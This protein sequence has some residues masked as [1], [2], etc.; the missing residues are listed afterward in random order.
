MTT[1]GEWAGTAAEA[2]GS[3]SSLHSYAM[4]CGV[5]RR[6]SRC[7]APDSSARARLAC[8]FDSKQTCSDAREVLP[9]SPATYLV[10]AVSARLVVSSRGACGCSRDGRM[11]RFWYRVLRDTQRLV[12]VASMPPA[13]GLP[14]ATLPCFGALAPAR[15]VAR[16]PNPVHRFGS[17]AFLHGRAELQQT[18][19][20]VSAQLL[21]RNADG[22]ERSLLPDDRIAWQESLP[23]L[24]DEAT[25]ADA[26][27]DGVPVDV[28]VVSTVAEAEAAVQVLL[29][30]AGTK[31][32]P[33]YHAIDTEAC[34]RERSGCLR[35]R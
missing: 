4:S 29:A 28:S 17:V 26:P 33:V 11:R 31:G 21:W 20:R 27:S 1:S 25:H 14:A 18:Q 32:K 22:T 5:R 15:N 23:A 9:L 34:L 8:S 16:Q 6:F 24:S 30:T 12:H 2:T 19:Q 10:C 3:A 13:A 7:D 35:A